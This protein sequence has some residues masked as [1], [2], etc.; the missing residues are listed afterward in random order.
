MMN[1]SLASR[2]NRPCPNRNHLS[3]R[4]K[5]RQAA[6]GRAHR[7]SLPGHA[8]RGLDRIWHRRT[9]RHQD[10]L[11][12][13][14]WGKRRRLAVADAHLQ[15][16]RGAQ[17]AGGVPNNVPSDVIWT[18]DFHAVLESDAD[19]VI[20]LIGGLSPAG[21][22]VRGALQAGQV[23]DHCQQAIIARH[24]PELLQLAGPRECGWNSRVGG[25]WSSGTAG[26]AHGFVRRPAARHCG[27]R[28]GTCNYILSRI[29]SARIPFSCP[30]RSPGPRICRSR[31]LGRS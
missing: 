11:R 26:V 18:N 7:R 1:R 2:G 25:G 16:E 10:S 30:G 5:Q 21:E 24:G 31:R 28:N 13:G 3:S 29:E 9:R 14:S 17:E 4:R 6:H 19:I 27:N 22:I 8:P 12:N 23:S 20:E 15:P